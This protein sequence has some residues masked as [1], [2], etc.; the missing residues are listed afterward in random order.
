[1]F[2]A[3]WKRIATGNGEIDVAHA[4]LTAIAAALDESCQRGDYESVSDDDIKRLFEIAT[5]LFGL[6]KSAMEEID[7]KKIFEHIEDHNILEEMIISARTKI[8]SRFNALIKDAMDPL[9]FSIIGH[10]E[11]MD[12]PL[13]EAISLK[14]RKAPLSHHRTSDT[15]HN[16]L[17]ARHLPSGNGTAKL[18]SDHSL[19]SDGAS[20]LNAIIINSYSSALLDL[21][22]SKWIAGDRAK[23]VA[24]EI[25]A[26][27]ISS[28]TGK[29]LTAD[30]VKKVILSQ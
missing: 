28:A 26:R 29:N 18:Q 8:S 3:E 13:A 2:A 9:S 19:H 25:V 23:T 1:M 20:S 7:Y 5:R 4:E 10:I 11:T 30:F 6:E 21:K 27:L 24:Y 15:G 17:P 16:A 14:S 12:V 22:E